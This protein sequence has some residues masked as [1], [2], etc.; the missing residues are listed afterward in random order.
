MTRR[1]ARSMGP[2]RTS[3]PLGTTRTRLS[4][5]TRG[6]GG[7]PI[8]A[9]TLRAS[10]CTAH[11][12]SCAAMIGRTTI[13][14]SHRTMMVAFHF[15]FRRWRSSAIGLLLATPVKRSSTETT[16]PTARCARFGKT[17]GKTF[18]RTVRSAAIRALVFPDDA[19]GDAA[20]LNSRKSR[21]VPA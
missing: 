15:C 5:T 10:W 9:D 19:P 12:A 8:V 16:A 17:I 20:G 14:R 13:A 7:A 18:Q 3:R 6:L 21:E 4:R 1:S 2:S 11:R